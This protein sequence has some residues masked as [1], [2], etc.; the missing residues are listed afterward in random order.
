MTLHDRNQQQI[1]LALSDTNRY[2][3]WKHYGVEAPDDNA[4]VIYFAEF[5]AKI[6]AETHE[7]TTKET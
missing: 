4:L 1:D 3:Y 2:Y 5:G 6:F 7:D